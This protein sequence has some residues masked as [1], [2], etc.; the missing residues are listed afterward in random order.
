MS[1]SSF[2]QKRCL[3]V[4]DKLCSRRTSQMF[5]NP[6]D[7]ERDSCPNYFDKVKTPMDL[8]TVRTKLLSG[9]YKSVA[10]WKADVNLI[11]SN[12]NAYNS[13]TSLLRSITKDL[14]DFYHKLTTY[15]T[16]SP[17]NDWTEKLNSLA[18]EMNQIMKEMNDPSNDEIVTPTLATI[19]TIPITASSSHDKKVK[20]QSKIKSKPPQQA[21]FQS[22]LS[23]SPSSASF[24]NISSSFS[25]NSS[26]SSNQQAIQTRKKVKKV[27]EKDKY[28]DGSVPSNDKEG[29]LGGINESNYSERVI[30]G[31]DEREKKHLSSRSFSKDQLQQ[32]SHDINFLE[33]DNQVNAILELMKANE[34]DFKDTGGEIEVDLNTLRSSTLRIIREQVDNFIESSYM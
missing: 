23:A 17:Q 27:K 10:D 29:Q 5:A 18:N 2:Q 7:P 11:W 20:S 1:L 28:K 26:S 16:D 12:S 14:S 32:L 21:H 30:F 9:Q 22:S 13:K 4:M 25:S 8:G 3:E 19:P 15:L 24:S 34:S 6:V 33:D 31:R